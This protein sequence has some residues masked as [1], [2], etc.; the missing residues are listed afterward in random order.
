MTARQIVLMLVYAV[1]FYGLLI[2][3]LMLFWATTA[4]ILGSPLP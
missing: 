4:A 2:V 1:A 3:C